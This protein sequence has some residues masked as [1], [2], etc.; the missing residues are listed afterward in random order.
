MN[1]DEEVLTLVGVVGRPL[2]G[3]A[4]LG[5]VGRVE[6]G[7]V[8]TTDGPGSDVSVSRDECGSSEKSEDGSSLDLKVSM[9]PAKRDRDSRSTSCEL[10][11]RLG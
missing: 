11:D 6:S 4:V 3:R 8:D 9:G 10:F 7:L 5:S 1:E 2:S